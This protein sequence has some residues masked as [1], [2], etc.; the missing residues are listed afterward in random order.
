MQTSLIQQ[1]APRDRNRAGFT[2]IEIVVVVSIIAILGAILVGV[3]GRGRSMARIAQCDTHLK[4]IAMALD[5]FRAENGRLPLSIIELSD[6]KYVQLES[7]RCPADPGLNAQAANASYSS[8][9]DFYAIREPRDSGELPVV[10]C[11]LH[12]D[13]GGR[14]LQAYKGRYTKQFATQPA[15]LSATDVNGAVTVTRPG[16]GSLAL[17]TGGDS[18]VLRGGDRITTGAGTATI[19]FVDGSKALVKANSDISVMQSYIEGERSGPLYTLIRQFSG[20]ATYTVK[21]GNHFDVATPTA[22]AGALGTQFDVDVIPDPSAVTGTRTLKTE[23]EVTESVVAITTNDFTFNVSA[24]DANPRVN[25]NDPSNK[26][27]KKH[28]PRTRGNS[29]KDKKD[30]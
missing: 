27:N 29:G 24:E 23:V 26:K 17:P 16:K 14:G 1:N 8:Y 12:E 10:V 3:F 25:A 9:S 13:L 5:T 15:T 20:S 28:Q 18:L 19:K 11:P 4:E 22:T 2:L 21:T 6:K 30:K 7:L